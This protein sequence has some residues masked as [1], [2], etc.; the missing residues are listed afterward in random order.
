MYWSASSLVF[1]IYAYIYIYIYIVCKLSRFCLLRRRNRSPRYLA[2]QRPLSEGRGAAAGATADRK[3][4]DGVSTNGI[5]ANS[6]FV[7]RGT[8]WVPIC[9]TLS[10]SDNFDYL[11]SQ[12]DKI[13]DFAATPLVLTQQASR[14]QE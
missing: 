8:F 6:M 1:D 3:G 5:T 4:A 10:K 13:I 2:C 14:K 7:D 9:Q 11:F 12:S